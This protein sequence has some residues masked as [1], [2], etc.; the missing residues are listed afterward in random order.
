LR[1]LR[2][3]VALTLGGLIYANLYGDGGRGVVLA[4]GGRFDKDSWEKQA[5]AL[6][7]SGFRVL[8]NGLPRRGSVAGRNRAA[9]VDE[10]RRFDVLAARGKLKK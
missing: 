3:A 6:S 10:G 1:T 7:A 9:S 8:A 5:Q 2:A 4:H